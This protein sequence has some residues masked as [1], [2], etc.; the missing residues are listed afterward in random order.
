MFTVLKNMKYKTNQLLSIK[1]LTDFSLSKSLDLKKKYKILVIDDQGFSQEESLKKMGYKDIT[2]EF[3]FT[4]IN[5]IIP[6]DIVLC[7]INGIGLEFDKKNQGAAV[8]KIIKENFPTKIVIIFSAADQPLDIAENYSYVDDVITKNMNANEM[9]SNI[10]RYI[11]MLDNPIYR[12][13]KIK[14]IFEQKQIQTK[15]IAIFEHYYVKTILEGK[16]FTNDI[17][18]HLK[19]INKSKLS[20]VLEKS[21]PVFVGI[22]KEVIQHYV[23][24]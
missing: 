19:Y 18:S 12:W 22:L 21:L 20:S 9:S 16:D 5:H 14:K 3:D 4:D 1:D 17:E 8:A 23:S 24:E 15:D 13:E 10:D 11:D 2:V 6:Y 7:D